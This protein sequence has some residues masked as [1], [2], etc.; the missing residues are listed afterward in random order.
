MDKK[1][2][3]RESEFTANLALAV[4][5]KIVLNGW[6]VGKNFFVAKKQQPKNK[7]FNWSKLWYNRGLKGNKNAS[8]AA[9]FSKYKSAL[10]VALYDNLCYNYFLP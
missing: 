5:P 9:W 1:I 7:P 2:N 6:T 4:A 10:N 3:L 8:H